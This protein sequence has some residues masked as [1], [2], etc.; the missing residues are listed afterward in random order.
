MD[1]TRPLAIGLFA[2]PG[3]SAGPEAPLLRYVRSFQPYLMGV[4]ARLCVVGETADALGTAGLLAGYA[5][6]ERLLPAAEGGLISL[7]ARLVGLGPGDPGLDWMVFLQDPTDVTALYPETTALRRE[8]VVHARP[9][10]ATE[11]AAAEW[12]ALEWRRAD[13]AGAPPALIRH[14]VRPGDLGQETLGLI[15]HDRRKADLLAFAAAHRGLLGR[16]GRRL[17]TGTTG[18]LLN[19][20]IPAR[21]AGRIETP[22]PPTSGWVEALRSG[23]Q[24]GDAQIAEAVVTGRCRRVV[25]FEDPHVAREHEADIQLLERATRFSK[26]GCLCLNNRETADRWA[27]NLAAVVGDGVA[28]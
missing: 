19:G 17:A 6:L 16:F 15:A 1:R 2:S 7:A 13:P 10:L 4:G 3:L 28:G 24:G 25:F 9:F 11:A 8:C 27:E 5:G 22:L 21:L 18:T 12:T 20:E 14:W 26:Q 23:P